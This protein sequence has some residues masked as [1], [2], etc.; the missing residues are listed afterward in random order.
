MV[1]E[2]GGGQEMLKMLVAKGVSVNA[3]DVAG[4]TPLHYAAYHGHE[5]PRGTSWGAAA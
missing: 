5:V 4:H 1:P 2:C 3:V